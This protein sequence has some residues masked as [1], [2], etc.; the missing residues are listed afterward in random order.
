[1]NIE[2]SLSSV[3]IMRGFLSLRLILLS[4]LVYM[5][6]VIFVGSEKIKHVFIKEK[7]DRVGKIQNGGAGKKIVFI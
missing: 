1:M 7:I 4:L 2:E 3:R 6:S 5:T